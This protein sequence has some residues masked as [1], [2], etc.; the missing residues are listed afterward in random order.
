M[1]R[2][3]QMENNVGGLVAQ[4]EVVAELALSAELALGCAPFGEDLALLTYPLTAPQD[5]QGGRGEQVPAS[6]EGE[7]GP[8]EQQQQPGSQPGGPGAQ[9]A[10]GPGGGGG[11]PA[12]A[13]GKLELRAGAKPEVGLGPPCPV[14]LWKVKYGTLAL[15]CSSRCV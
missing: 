1:V 7:A 13:G 4:V 10:L 12:R 11:A 3:W 5:Q 14:G 15:Q 9:E 6:G 2:V 8:E